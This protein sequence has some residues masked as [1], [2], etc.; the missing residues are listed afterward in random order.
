MTRSLAVRLTA[1]FAACAS[2]VFV[3]AGVVIYMVL[4]AG[5]HDQLR[6]ELGLRGGWV[7]SSVLRTQSESQ[8][9]LW[10][11]PTMDAMEAERSGMRVWLISDQPGFRYGTPSADVI[12]LSRQGGFGFLQDHGR[13][14]AW[15]TWSRTLPADGDRPEVRL[16]LAKDPA[17]F[18][19]TLNAFRLM[20][21]VLGSAGVVVVALLGH[22]MARF[23]LRPLRRLSRQAQALD[24]NHKGQ[25]LALKPMPAELDDLTASFNGALARLETAYQQLEGF[26]ADVAHELRTPLTNLIGQTQVMLTRP[27]SNAELEEVLHSNLEDM[28]RLKAIVNDMLFLARADQGAAASRQLAVCMADEVRKVAEFLEPLFDE[29]GVTLRVEGDTKCSVETAL[30]RRALSNLMRNAIQHATPGDEVQASI[31]REGAQVRLAIT[32][33]GPEIPAQHLPHLFDRFYRVDSARLN[34]G[35]NHGLGLAIVNAIAVMHRGTVFV[36]S[37]NGLNTFGLLLPA[38]G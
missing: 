14:P 30:L 1:L 24:P 28:E 26:N 17:R 12:A 6:Y 10:L 4:Q 2:V 23:G 20:L 16:V 32:N 35:G 11:T 7:E 33:P 19:D 37:A 9:R 29:R 3:V 27:R 36:E 13:G 22:G 18:W 25:R 21:I 15:M 31:L 5:I 8:W 34:S 38:E